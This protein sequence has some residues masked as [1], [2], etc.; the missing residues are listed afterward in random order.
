[1]TSIS[2]EGVVRRHDIIA[3]R[4]GS[5]CMIGMS[6]GYMSLGELMQNGSHESFK[7]NPVH[8]GSQR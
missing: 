6:N 2:G 7:C 8:Q 4:R 5:P 1:M 3:K